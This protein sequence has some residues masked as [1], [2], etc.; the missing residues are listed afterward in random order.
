MKNNDKDKRKSSKSPIRIPTFIKSQH[1]HHVERQTM[2]DDD[3]NSGTNL[4]PEPET[5]EMSSYVSRKQETTFSPI[6]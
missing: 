2:Y 5:I 4:L 3:F 6:L 1:P